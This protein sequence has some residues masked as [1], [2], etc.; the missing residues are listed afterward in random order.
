MLPIGPY[1]YKVYPAQL[2]G[3]YG[4]CDSVSDCIFIDESLFAEGQ[5]AKLL[6]TICH[7]LIEAI[8]SVYDLEIPHS[9]IQ[10]LGASFAQALASALAAYVVDV[11]RQQCPPEL[12]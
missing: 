8:V 12:I 5:E 7:E 2:N 10:T 4:L 11:Y 3:L 6:D 1:L 9:T